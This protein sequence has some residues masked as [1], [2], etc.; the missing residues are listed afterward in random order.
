VA[1]PDFC[2]QSDRELSRLCFGQMIPQL[3]NGVLIEIFGFSLVC[4]EFREWRF[5]SW[6]FLLD[7]CLIVVDC[8]Y[9]MLRTDFHAKALRKPT[10]EK[11]VAWENAK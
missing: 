4:F 9:K 1:V 6:K 5:R 8:M 3:G 10:T 7:H 11:L 2:R